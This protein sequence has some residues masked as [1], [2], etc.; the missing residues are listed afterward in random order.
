MRAS[1]VERAVMYV[2]SFDVSTALCAPVCREERG[3]L[4]AHLD[5]RV[6]VEEIAG[7]RLQLRAQQPLVGDEAC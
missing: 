4:V 3:L 1:M 7:V 6:A 2:P 5:A